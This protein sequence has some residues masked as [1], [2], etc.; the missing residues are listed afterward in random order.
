MKRFNRISENECPAAMDCGA[1]FCA[2]NVSEYLCYNI[3]VRKTQP[4]KPAKSKT[5]RRV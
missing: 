2:K 3:L 1:F 5:K 4:E